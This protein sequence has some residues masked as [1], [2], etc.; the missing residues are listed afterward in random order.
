M[1]GRFSS[2][3]L[4]FN[5]HGSIKFYANN[6]KNDPH[7]FKFVVE[8]YI[9]HFFRIVSIFLVTNSIFSYALFADANII[10]PSKPSKINCD[11]KC[12]CY[13]NFLSWPQTSRLP[14]YSVLK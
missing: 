11:E 8:F 10:Y 13:R 2:S 4:Y 9:K 6:S 3:N 5:R 7:L 14:D 12:S 1:A